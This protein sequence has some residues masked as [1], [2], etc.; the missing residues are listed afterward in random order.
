VT[1]AQERVPHLVHEL[2]A[3]L[4][5]GACA[6]QA[7]RKEGLLDHLGL[8]GR[9]RK[10]R[11]F[12]ARLEAGCQFVSLLSVKFPDTNFQPLLAQV[13]SLGVDAV[14]AFFSGGGAVQFVRT[15]Q[16]RFEGAA[17][18][19]GFLTDGLLKAQGPARRHRDGAALR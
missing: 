8:R 1:S 11:R 18:R 15:T 9:H 6:G 4:R 19:F 7:G 3:G 13:P 16:R 5:H 12:Q 17:V 14:G 10:R 2:A